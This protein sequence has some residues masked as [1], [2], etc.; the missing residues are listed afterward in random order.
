M[1]QYSNALAQTPWWLTDAMQSKEQSGAA[2]I[3]AMQSIRSRDTSRLDRLTI[4]ARLYAGRNI[5]SLTGGSSILGAYPNPMGMSLW[6][7]DRIRYNIIQSIIDTLTARVG[8]VRPMPT[9]ITDSGDWYGKRAAQDLETWTEGTFY[10]TKFYDL[11]PIVFR[12]AAWAGTGIAHVFRE[13]GRI[14]IERVIPGELWVDPTDAA[15]GDPRSLY[16]VKRMDQWQ[17]KSMFPQYREQIDAAGAVTEYPSDARTPNSQQVEVI[18]AWHLPSAPK[19]KDGRHVI[20]I[21]GQTLLYEDWNRP[22]F[23]FAFLQWSPPVA[24]FWGQGASERLKFIQVEINVILQRIQESF[25]LLAKPTVYVEEGSKVVKA[26]LNNMV[27]SILTYRGTQPFV[28]TP[29]TVHPEVFSQLDRLIARAYIQEGVTELSA[30]GRVEPGLESGKAIRTKDDIETDRFSILSRQ[31]ESFVMDVAELC[32]TEARE[33]LEAREPLEGTVLSHRRRGA[34]KVS[35]EDI[36]LT[37][38]QY[39]MHVFPTSA[40]ARTPQA[41]LEDVQDMMAAGLIDPLVGR[42][43]LDFPD[44]QY[45]DDVDFAPLDYIDWRVSEMLEHGN[46][47]APNAL[48]S[49]DL[50]V[51][52]VQRIWQREAVNGCPEDRL[53][54]LKRY[55]DD[56]AEMLLAAQAP[57]TQALPAGAPPGQLPPQPQAPQLPVQVAA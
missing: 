10:Q 9:Y 53:D 20:A 35:F 51:K 40:L 48:Q 12:D 28:V 3:A 54:L 21:D 29:Q 37:S 45:E 32:H 14:K 38:D 46:Y 17:L 52:R 42:R 2:V 4:H 36:K 49:L 18:E 44:T 23:P 7:D 1:Q 5:L 19:A 26:H 57:P 15:F 16:R 34:R 8:K 11:I 24:G 25:R 22:T 6:E 43:L 39:V 47:E 33:A 13:H 55:I 50:T 56:A 30:G 31:T 27:G 41:R